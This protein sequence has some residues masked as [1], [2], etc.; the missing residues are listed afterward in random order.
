VWKGR[1]I[2]IACEHA[3]LGTSPRSTNFAPPCH[4]ETHCSDGPGYPRVNTISPDG[5][6]F[7][8]FDFLLVRTW[9]A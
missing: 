4:R 1:A 3:Q 9:R 8:F 6:V 7:A 2:S 5:S